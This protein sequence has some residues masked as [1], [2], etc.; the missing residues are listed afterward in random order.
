MGP[1]NTR[2]NHSLLYKYDSSLKE[3]K[4]SHSS[5]EFIQI[6]GKGGFGKVWKVYSKKY[7]SSYAMKEMLKVKIIDKKSEKNVKREIDLLSIMNHPFIINM[8]FSFQDNHYLYIAMDLLTGG[9]LR[10]QISKIRKFTEE[11][12]KFFIA[13]TILSLE[14]LHKNEIIHRDLKPENLVLDSKGYVKLTDFG[15]ANKYIKNNSRET[16]GTPG[17]MSPEV[18]CRQNHTIA[19]DYFA[20]GVI[21]YELM[22]GVRPYLGKNRKEI[23]EKIMAKQVQVKKKQIPKNWSIDSADF[24]NRLLQRKPANRLGLRGPTEVKEHP[25]F[26]A[27]PWKELYLGKIDAPFIPK[28]GD[29]FNFKHCNETDENGIETQERYYNILN[30]NRYFRVFNEFANFNRYNILEN[31]FDVKKKFINPHDIYSEINKFNEDNNNNDNDIINGN[32]VSKRN[33]NIKF[34]HSSSIKNK[35]LQAESRNF[36]N[37]NNINSLYK[38]PMLNNS[39][40]TVRKLSSSHSTSLYLKGIKKSNNSFNCSLINSTNISNSGISSNI[41]HS[42]EIIKEY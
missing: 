1:K 32:I 42:N 11:Q 27:F 22:N 17:Y 35:I 39:Y 25:W 12:T 5:F 36:N 20:L 3:E 14:Y 41:R 7:K 24:I 10:Y 23:K 4:L 2:Q 16:S 9:D 19:V 18:M 26:K 8:H 33:V 38:I 15:I 37:K 34:N 30:S 28:D 21:G 31:E 40:T 13:C 6:I 29:N